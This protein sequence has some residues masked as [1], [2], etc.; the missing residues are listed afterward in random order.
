MTIRVLKADKM[1]VQSTEDVV[2]VRQRVRTWA[3]ELGLNLVDQ[4]KVIT[5]A[6]ELA[7]NAVVHG[8][9]GIVEFELVDNGRQ[10]GLRLTFEDSGP[11]IRDVE[12]AMRDGYTTGSG[13]G[14]GLGGARRLSNEFE[15]AS[16]PGGTRVRILRWK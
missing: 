14:L 8:G 3:I 12:A 16:Q 1:P 15:I 10:R 6:S 11:G 4:T 2:Q 9:G 7:R 13:L 5:A